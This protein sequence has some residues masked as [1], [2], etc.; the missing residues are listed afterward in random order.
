M[1]HQG[2]L[3]CKSVQSV[4]I[5]NELC[6]YLH[7]RKYI[8][9]VFCDISTALDKIWYQSLLIKLQRYGMFGNVLK[10]IENY[11]NERSQREVMNIISFGMFDVI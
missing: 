4:D 7:S 1:I 5:S 3:C 9:V 8:P 6:K 2:G 10:W 11:L